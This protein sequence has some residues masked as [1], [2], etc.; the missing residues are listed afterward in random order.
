V[1]YG[2]KVSFT[3]VLLLVRWLILEGETVFFVGQIHTQVP[4]APSQTQSDQLDVR[5]WLK[6]DLKA[7]MK[8]KNSMASMV[9]RVSEF[10][11]NPAPRKRRNV[12]LKF[13]KI[14]SVLA[15]VTNLEKAKGSSIV[16]DTIIYGAIRKAV[17]RRVRVR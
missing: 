3:E 8:A 16:N 9:I 2:K 13:G 4:L 11:M 6:S 10:I 1:R 15:E 12:H 14:Q 5:S 7:A 17:A